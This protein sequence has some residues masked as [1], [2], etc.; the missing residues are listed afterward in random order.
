[1]RSI[2]RIKGP[3]IKDKR[4]T[5]A[6]GQVV[7]G[8]SAYLGKVRGR[9]RIVRTISDFAGFAKGDIVISPMTTVDFTPHLGK[10]AAIVTDEGGITCHAAIVARELRIPC[11]IGTG[12]ATMVF[13]DGDLVEVDANRGV[14]RKL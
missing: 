11:V 6:K 8:K 14:V 12:E 9:A 10:A 5:S 3:E 1:M 13:R 2:D 4:G 7:S